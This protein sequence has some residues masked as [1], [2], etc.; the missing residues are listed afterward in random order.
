MNV[1]I[2]ACLLGYC[3]R[4]DGSNNG[5]PIDELFELKKRYHLSPI[6]PEQLGGLTTPRLPAE[7]LGDRV[8]N[9]EGDDITAAYEKGAREA[10]RMAKLFGCTTAIL[11]SR[12]PSCGPT[13]VYDGT[14][15]H[16]VVQR[17]GTTAE[18]LL[19]N[20]LE[21]LD[22]TQIARLLV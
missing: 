16:T 17:P 21:V 20:G 2:S 22:E 5:R 8:V 7:R 9:T 3:C 19:A 10:L 6:C 13:E 11:K 4:Y 1:L 18:L 15:T 12:S 14:F